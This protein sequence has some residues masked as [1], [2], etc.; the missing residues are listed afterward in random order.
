MI[1]PPMI[2]RLCCLLAALT[3]PAAVAR[4]EELK[5]YSGA[6]CAAVDDYFNDEVW[7]K[8]VAHSCV[9]CHREGGDAEDS[10]LVLKDP[11]RIEAKDI[12]AA[13]QQNR[14]A[15]LEMAKKKEGADSRLL[16]KA[17]GKLKHEGEEAVKP[18][19]VEY[20]VLA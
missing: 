18:D 17:T 20:K 9:K 13:M 1:L 6:G 2:P 16:L 12:P 4:A 7:G 10:K 14:A 5:P 19:S 11:K 15:F 8:V 3:L